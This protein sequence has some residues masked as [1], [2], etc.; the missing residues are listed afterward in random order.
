MKNIKNNKEL[1]IIVTI[2]IVFLVIFVVYDKIIKI[3]YEN[4]KAVVDISKITDWKDI[5]LNDARFY[6]IYNNLKYY[7]YTASRGFGIDDF[8]DYELAD[9]GFAT[10]EKDRVFA[11]D[12]VENDIDVYGTIRLDRFY[13]GIEKI[14]N[15]KITINFL[16]IPG[17]DGYNASLIFDNDTVEAWGCGFKINGYDD[18]NGNVFVQ[19]NNSCGGVAIYDENITERKIVSAKKHD[20]KIVVVEKVIYYVES[21]DDDGNVYCTIYAD[22]QRSAIIDNLYI[23]AGEVGNKKIVVD[24]Y[25]NRASTIIHTFKLNKNNNK[26]YFLGSVIK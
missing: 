5:K 26:Y 14:F 6:N 12:R 17:F 7:T 11:R 10:A 2:L 8:T 3:K 24:D 25:I 21:I 18:K 1:V 16:K 19:L 4:D 23:E 22:P 15:R 13:S 9:I 20:D